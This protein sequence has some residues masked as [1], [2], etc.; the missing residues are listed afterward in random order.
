MTDHITSSSAVLSANE[1]IEL[2]CMEIWGGNEAVDTAISVPGLDVWVASTPYGGGAQGGDIHYLSMCGSGRISRFA[3]ADVA[4][5]GDAVGD[6]AATL[7]RLMRKN[8]NTLDQ[9]R[10]ARDLNREFG[11]LNAA[12][13]FATALLTTYFAPTNQLILVNAGHPRPLWHDAS[14]S[15][16]R[17]LDAEHSDELDSG[18]GQAR[19]T[20]WGSPVSNLPLGVIEPTDYAQ[21]AIRLEPGDLVLIYT[22]SLIE[23]QS[24]D[25]TMLGEAGLL[26]LVERLDASR[27]AEAIVS[28]QRMLADHRGGAAPDD[29]QTVLL[30]HHNGTPPPPMT[31]KQGLRSLAKM[32]GLLSV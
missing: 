24:P 16:W 12:G 5:H 17:A 20:Y 19:A 13:R 18:A 31:V 32:V 10:F 21:F 30:L 29:D 11:Q 22:D 2:Q 9:T 15:R 6:L 28:L 23:A 27:P 14:A 26:R 1:P 25:G 3:V 8:I 7:R 4:G